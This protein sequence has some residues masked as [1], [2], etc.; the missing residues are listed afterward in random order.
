MWRQRPQGDHLPRSS[1]HAMKTPPRSQSSA[2]TTVAM[3]RVPSEISRRQTAQ[4]KAEE[5]NAPRKAWPVSGTRNCGASRH[6]GCVCVR[7]YVSWL[8]CFCGLGV[9]HAIVLPG[10]SPQARC[11]TVFLL[12]SYRELA[13]ATSWFDRDGLLPR[14]ACPM[15]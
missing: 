2:G 8:W 5:Q 15:R 11:E 9:T 13:L 14:D 3:C 4:N 10:R 7:V 1:G 6:Q 12:S